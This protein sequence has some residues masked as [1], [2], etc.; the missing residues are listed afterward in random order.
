MTLQT[1]G[2]I[3][4]NEINRELKGYTASGT[5]ISLGSTTSRRMAS[6]IGNGAY[7]F[8]GPISMSDFYGARSHIAIVAGS[9]STPGGFVSG[10]I[11]DYYGSGSH[12][13]SLNSGG[14]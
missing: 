1:S 9:V 2:P 12:L 6:T 11:K 8:T 10:Y 7:K 13:G 4:M 3:S 5:S 14:I